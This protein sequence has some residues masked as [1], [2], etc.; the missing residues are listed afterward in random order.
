MVWACP[1]AAQMRL[2]YHHVCM[3]SCP[4][5]FWAKSYRA[6]H[7]QLE[8]C[9]ANRSQQFT[10]WLEKTWWLCLTHSLSL[11]TLPHAYPH[12]R[13]R[14]WASAIDLTPM[15]IDAKFRSIII[16]S[17]DTVRYTH[18]IDLAIKHIQPALVVGP[19]GTGALADGH[20]CH[21]H[22]CDVHFG[23]DRVDVYVC[24]HVSVSGSMPVGVCTLCLSCTDPTLMAVPV[25]ALPAASMTYAPALSTSCN[26]CLQA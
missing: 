24:M 16:P 12:C 11:T 17:M 9:I 6:F 19:T 8:M 7:T 15:P 4:E 5:S 10:L 14:T 21:V 23:G 13:W 1:S 25:W 3:E 22:L 18:L 2:A 20:M 26:L